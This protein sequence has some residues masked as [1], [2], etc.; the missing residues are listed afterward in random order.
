MASIGGRWV[1]VQWVAV[2]DGSDGGEKERR[3]V[4]EEREITVREKRQR[5]KN[6]GKFC[7]G[8]RV[9]GKNLYIADE[10]EIS[11]FQK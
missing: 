2:A 4:R 6:L 1:A 11:D 7:E 3:G 9:K 8:E 5:E 10:K